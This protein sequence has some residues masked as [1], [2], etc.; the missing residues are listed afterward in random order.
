MKEL[1]GAATGARDLKFG[2]RNGRPV[3]GQCQNAWPAAGGRSARGPAQRR[4]RARGGS[5]ARGSTPEPGSRGRPASVVSLLR[6]AQ[7]ALADP[8][9]RAAV[10]ERDE[11][12]VVAG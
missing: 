9:Q 6:E 2:P 7:Q 12:R 5:R 10:G 11:Q 4:P 3:N 8:L 1:Q